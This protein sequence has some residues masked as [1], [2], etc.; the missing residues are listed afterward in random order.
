LE[1]RKVA[2]RLICDYEKT[3]EDLLAGLTND[4]LALAIQIAQTPME[5]RG[6]GH[7]KAATIEAAEKKQAE[8]MDQFRSNK[9]EALAAE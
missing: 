9:Q 5:I 7:I 3:I 8:L 1:E 4:N 6:Y 2:R